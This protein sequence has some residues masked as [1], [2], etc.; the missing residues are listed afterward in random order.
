[1]VLGLESVSMRRVDGSSE[2]WSMIGIAVVGRMSG[3]Y[4]HNEVL[5]ERVVKDGKLGQ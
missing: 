5:D 3:A 4:K 1:M 2:L